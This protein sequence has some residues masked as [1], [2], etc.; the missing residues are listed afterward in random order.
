MIPMTD[1]I[2][3][4]IL[5]GGSGTRLWPVSR[6]TWPK[7]FM[8]MAGGASLLA[9]TLERALA[10]AAPGAP[11]LTITG[12]DHYFITRDEYVA[13][14]PAAMERHRFLLE[15][16]ARNTAPA[17]LLGAL[18]V[19]DRH[20]GEALLLVLPADHLVGDAAGFAESVHRAAALARQ[21][22][23]VTFGIAPTRAETGYGYIRRGAALDGLGYEIE[24]FVEKPG[25]DAAQ[26][27]LASGEYLWNAGM[28]CFSA[29]ALLDAASTSCPDVLDAARTCH[30][31]TD[32][33][34]RVVEFPGEAFRAIP[35]ISIDYAV[36]ERAAHR[37]VVPAAFDWNDIGSWTAV[38]EQAPP[39]ARGNRV[40]GEAVLVD[41]DDCFVQAET[42][43][44]ALVGVEDLAVVETADAVL[45]AH[46]DRAQD[47][48]RAVEALRARAHPSTEH[49][50]TVFRPWGSYT[51][52]E[53]A[54][55]CK[56][57]RLTVKPGHVLSLQY[58]HR[59]SEHWTVVRG[60]AKVRV[61][62]VETVLERNQGTFIPMGVVHR[63]ENP[64]SEDL[65][66][67]ETQCG[68]YFGEDDIVRLEDVYGRVKG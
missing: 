57:K 25:L 66:L 31:A 15:P 47:V 21:G 55:D 42:R 10:V 11:V 63:L 51:V 14:A 65:H 50:V 49:H 12:R 34:A 24:R 16:A 6:R 48:K 28:F 19:A 32:R 62:D 44:V 37:A 58:H 67:I 22:R 27:Y 20:G 60:T 41:A 1:P 18:D 46:R 43:A 40:V 52:L 39:D 36:M 35:E 30:L 45:V 3:P 26:S 23:L 8:R 4:L 59:R 2:V 38:S 33:A 7:P 29:R 68:D 13:A 5:S 64:G 54:P 17:I 61:G 9:R 56:V 53:D